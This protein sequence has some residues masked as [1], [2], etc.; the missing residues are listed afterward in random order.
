MA[1]V[2]QFQTR[3]ERVGDVREDSPALTT[4]ESTAS[5]GRS[6]RPWALLRRFVRFI[7]TGFAWLVFLVI[8]GNILEAYQ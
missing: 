2:I 8:V 3:G 1:E 5:H 7:L 6:Q 4:H